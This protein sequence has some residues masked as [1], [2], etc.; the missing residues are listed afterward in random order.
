MFKRDLSDICLV[1]V[2]KSRNN[3]IH[4]CYITGAYNRRDPL[5]FYRQGISMVQAGHKVSYIVC[6]NQEDEVVNGINIYSTRFVPKSRI[7]RF[8]KTKKRVLHLA[9]WVDADIYQLS[10]PEHI[11][12]VK[13]FRK[14]GKAVVFNMREYYPDFLKRKGYLPSF[15]RPVMAWWFG[16]LM[17]YYYPK[18]GAIFS[19]DAKDVELLKKKFG[20][21]NAYLAANF[22]I[23]EVNYTV[24]KEDYMSRK[25][26]VI[27]EGTIYTRSRQDVFLDALARI[28]NVNYLLVGRL[29]DNLKEHPWWKNVEFI[30]GFRKEDLKGYFERST[31]SNTLR[32]FLS[33]DGSYGVLKIFESME[34]GLPVIL[35]DVPLYRAMVNKWHCG[36]L[37]DPN[38]VDSVEKAIR[39]LVENKEEAYQMGQ[40]G[41]RAVLKEYNWGKQFEVY[42]RVILDLVEKSKKNNQ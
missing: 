29:E 12:L 42:E 21:T 35:S 24:S 28:G 11:S 31:I 3:M 15:L 39:Y 8:M 36:V 1:I 23:P 13:Y 5:M 33:G 25:D 19:S 32:N 7:E 17:K 38:D 37:A 4:I 30:D 41:S 14:K 6:D 18:Y 26:T 40:N 22:P 27:Y 9:D 34:A 10:D 2:V 16:M 20:V